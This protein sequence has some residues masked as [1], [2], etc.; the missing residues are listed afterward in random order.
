MEKEEQIKRTLEIARKVSL[1]D[2]QTFA[3]QTLMKQVALSRMIELPSKQ[4]EFLLWLIEQDGKF[5]RETLDSLGKKEFSHLSDNERYGTSFILSL[6]EPMNIVSL[7]SNAIRRQQLGS[8]GE[9]PEK[10]IEFLK[11]WIGPDTP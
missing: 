9:H 2:E 6:F 5:D 11:C 4:R 1:D 7:G 3:V 8:W 10:M